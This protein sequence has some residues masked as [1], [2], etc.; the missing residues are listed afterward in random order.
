MSDPREPI[1]PCL[2][3]EKTIGYLWNQKEILEKSA[4]RNLDFAC[5][6]QLVGDYGSIHDGDV[7]TAVIC[8]DCLTTLQEKKLVIHSGNYIFD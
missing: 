8:D 4:P 1:S 5:S 6:V 3:C 2:I 7:F